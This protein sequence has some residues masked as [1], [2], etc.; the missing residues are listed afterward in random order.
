MNFTEL[1][2]VME[3]YFRP[4]S[5]FIE[6]AL[7][8]AAGAYF[9][10]VGA[11][12]AI[13]RENQFRRRFEAINAANSAHSLAFTII[14][15]AA[16]LKIRHYLPQLKAFNR[17]KSLIVENNSKVSPIKVEIDFQSMPSICLP[18]STLESIVYGKLSL[19]GRP[20]AALAQLV[21]AEHTLKNLMESHE[22]IRLELQ[23]GDPSQAPIKYF[24]LASHA[25]KDDR[26]AHLCGHLVDVADD[27]IFFAGIFSDDIL[28]Y[29][30]Q[31]RSKARRSD[32]K[33]LPAVN[34]PTEIIEGHEEFMPDR[35]RYEPWL[36]GFRS[37]E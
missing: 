11:Q 25:G 1:V 37:G 4:T 6:T 10:A 14:N 3:P 29:A 30:N 21:Q 7:V 18:V 15:D 28:D 22:S 5:Y 23:N 2:G 36:K 35:E 33:T 20:L 12:K 19:N 17:N 8:A 32:R 16:S 9:G 24:G 31:V 27:L 13:N 34:K 26:F